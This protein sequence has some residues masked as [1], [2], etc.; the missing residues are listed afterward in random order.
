MN[1]EEER[2]IL[3]AIRDALA[4]LY[5]T[6]LDARRVVSQA[7]L[8]EK[9]IDFKGSATTFW[10]AILKEADKSGLV[11]TTLAVA[12]GEYP[13]NKALLDVRDNYWRRQEKYKEENQITS[14]GSGELVIDTGK[15]EFPLELPY[16]TVS[17][18][19][20]FYI[21]READRN[22][23]LYFQQGR[24]VTVFV[25]GPCE[26]GKSSLMHRTNYLT[27]VEQDV[28]IAYINLDRF[29]DRFFDNLEL[30]LIELC[31]QIGNMLN[32]PD[33]ID[34]YWSSRRGSALVKCSNYMT[35]HI[36]PTVNKPLILAIDELDKLLGAPFRNDFFGMLRTWH[37]DRAH[38]PKFQKLSLFLSSSTEPHLYIDKQNQSPFNVAQTVELHDFT[39]GEVQELNQRYGKLLHEDQIEKLM[40]LLNGHPLLIRLAFHTID[41]PTYDMKMLLQSASIEGGPFHGHLSHL[42]RQVNESNEL[43]QAVRQIYRSQTYPVNRIYYRLKGAGL[44]R[45]ID[46]KIVMRNKL[47]E[48]FF[49]ERLG[50]VS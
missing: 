36:L 29:E 3:A 19:S 48:R 47:Y 45:H 21:E 7:G 42:W 43:L 13:N 39:L 9:R 46:G 2:I 33:E 14:P 31:D 10:H 32:I 50:I 27:Q 38:D 15:T 24:A 23:I 44:I 34:Q 8:N 26:T 17:P 16:G 20:P 25:K 22:C 49:A 18:T 30:F 40:D 28:A 4:E 12:Q 41:Q 1:A 5:P 35:K 11:Q 6:E 37:N